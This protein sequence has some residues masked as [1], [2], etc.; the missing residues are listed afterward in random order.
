[1]FLPDS[2]A[3]AMLD[4]RFKNGPA[5]EL[6][7]ST[8]EPR[9]QGGVYVDVTEPAATDYSRVPVPA[10]AWPAASERAVQTDVVL[11][12]PVTDWG[13]GVAWV[14]FNTS[15]GAAEYAGVFEEGADLRAGASN[16]T[17]TARV[18]FPDSI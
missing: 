4:A 2:E 11:A 1:M 17:I 16:I 7:V 14:L 10:S 13:V 5:R 12:D 3:H 6:G 18:E 8:T 15:T 9:L